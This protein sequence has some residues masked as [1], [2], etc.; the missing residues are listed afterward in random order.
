MLIFQFAGH[1]HSSSSLGS[2]GSPRGTIMLSAEEGRAH[3]IKCPYTS[4][5]ANTVEAKKK[6]ERN[7]HL[8]Y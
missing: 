3:D 4:Y 2:N 5:G 6:K 7:F 1:N 8:N